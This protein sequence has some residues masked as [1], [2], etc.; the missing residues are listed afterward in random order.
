MEFKKLNANEN[1]QSYS[2]PSSVS[3]IIIRNLANTEKIFF[4][5]GTGTV[6][7]PEE[8]EFG[9]DL[10]LLNPGKEIEFN[11]NGGNFNSYA[12]EYITDGDD[13]GFSIITM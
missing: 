6:T 8:Y 9:E 4:S 12:L 11:N 5:F 10:F 1:K 7:D 3:K 13:A 2:I